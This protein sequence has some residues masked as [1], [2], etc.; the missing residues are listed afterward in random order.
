MKQFLLIFSTVVTFLCVNNAVAQVQWTNRFNGVGDFSRVFNVVRADGAGN[1]Y[2]GGYTLNAGNYKD[3]LLVK[4]NASGDTVFTRIYN[5]AGNNADD[6]LALALD[7]SGNIYVTG[8]QFGSTSSGD[9]VTMK[10][11]NSGTLLWTATYNG[12][13]NEYDQ[14]NSIA[15]DSLGNVYVAGESDGEATCTTNYDIVT[16]KY[17]ANGNQQWVVRKNGV[18]NGTDKPVKVLTDSALNVYVA[19]RSYNGSN[20]DYI[21]LKYNSSGVQQWQQT[22]DR[23][24]ND[25]ATDMVIDKAAGMLYVTGRSNSGNDFDYVTLKYNLAGALQWTKV[26]NN[27]ADDRATNIT[28]DNSGN[29][30]VTGQ[31][32]ASTSSVSNYNI[33]TVK[34]NSSGTQL[35]VQSWSGSGN[36]DDIPAAM[37]VDNA[38]NIYVSGQTDR[39]TTTAINNDYVLLKYTGAG[40]LRW[41]RTFNGGANAND[42][43]LWAA[44]D[45][46]ANVVITGSSESPAPQ[47]NATTLKY[48]SAGTLLWTK[49]YLA[50]GDN[51]DNSHAI[52]AD[53]S[54]NVYIAGYSVNWNAD[55]NYAVLKINSAGNKVW[56]REIDGTSTGSSDEAQAI[57]LDATGGIYVTGYIHNSCQASD[58][59]TTKFNTQGDTLWVQRYNYAVANGTDRGYSIALDASGNVYVTGRSDRDSSVAVNYDILTIKYSNAGVQQWVARYNGSGNGD[60]EAVTVKVAASGNVYVAGKTFNGTNEDYVVIKYNSSGVQQWAATYN[61]GHGDDVPTEMV[62]D[63]SENTYLTGYSANVVPTTTDVATVKFNSSGVQ[64]WARVYNGT[65]NGDDQGNSITLD[66]SGNVI[67]TGKADAD[68]SATTLNNDYL[69]IKYDNS[70]NQQWVQ[71]YNGLANAN[72]ESNEVITDASGN[73]YITGQSDNG[74]SGVQNYDY[75]TI[76]YSSSGNLT[77]MAAY[78]GTGNASDV[79]NTLTLKNN[80]LYIT[81]GSFGTASQRDLVTIK[82]DA[83]CLVSIGASG[84]TVICSGGSVTLSATTGAA[85]YQW[86]LNGGTI[87][88]A[89]TSS[90]SASS[91][92]NYTCVVT[93]S[94]GSITTNTITVVVVSNVTLNLKFFIQGYYLSGGTM[95]K[96]LYDENIDANAASTKVDTVLIE[97]HPAANTTT[98]AASYKGVLQ[99][100]GTLQCTFPCTV[101]GNLYYIAVKH[102]NMVETW[103]ASPVL[104]TALTNYDFSTVIT[105]A[106]ANNMI[107]VES[108]GI[109]S[110]YNGDINQ[111]SNVD[112]VDF[113]TMDIGINQGL[114]GYFTADLNGDGNVDLIDFPI[115]ERNILSGIFSQHP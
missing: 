79:A 52:A 45:N 84:S 94:C 4:L 17:N 3:M 109:W 55:R 107:D 64:Q 111:D 83:T 93:N 86:K 85:S 60:D 44:L 114:Y 92:G 58:V 35:W 6:I 8:Y 91:A 21:V 18:G 96:V 39:D 53:D 108:E 65:A 110:F 5:G 20:D 30:Y 32:N 99:T 98:V 26:Y 76:K 22:M 14:G 10:F 43:G 51:S 56:E 104:M 29:V 41:S 97:L 31:S 42:V 90:Y 113:P 87:S 103:S 95:Q 57:V 48:D 59:V 25:F 54:G 69:T 89:T 15:V 12:P 68:N 67:V 101:T 37:V 71:T 66:A 27:V 81:G 38:G 63:A 112:L 61:S 9:M 78:N 75:L 88:G 74:S 2:L 7:A 28:L 105:K 72:D 36:G 23:G 11:N 40:V 46:S 33:A 34:Y 106:Y 47:T 115:L 77:G 1:F 73:V 102:R 49:F 16:I 80:F 62:M 100:N 50:V 82:Y 24:H 70:G 19:G 13:V